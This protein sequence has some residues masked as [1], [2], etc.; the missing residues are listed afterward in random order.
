MLH[1]KT[2]LDLVS[3]EPSVEEAALK[4]EE[5][6]EAAVV[7]EAVVEV[8]VVVVVIDV[9][10]A[11]SYMKLLHFVDDVCVVHQKPLVPSNDAVSLTG[12]TETE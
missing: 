2:D 1:G 11:R 9:D 12:S 8:V 5:E 10:G 6:E 4:L 7:A 3:I